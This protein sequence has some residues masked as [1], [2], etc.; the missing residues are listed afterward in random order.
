[1]EFFSLKKVESGE[2][3]PKRAMEMEHMEA[4]YVYSIILLYKGGEYSN[5]YQ[6]IKLLNAV[7]KSRKLEEWRERTRAFILSMWVNNPI[8]KPQELITSCHAE[9]C[10]GRN[11]GGGGRRR[12]WPW[13]YERD[14]DVK[15][16][17]FCEA[18]IWDDEVSLFCKQFS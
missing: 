8:A 2:E 12:G 9:T 13:I 10:G 15:D 17:N 3:Y 6:G 1:M 7:K 18:C 11:N 4:S 16:D 5:E 14:E